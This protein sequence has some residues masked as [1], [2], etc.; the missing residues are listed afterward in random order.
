MA[1]KRYL[2]LWFP[3]LRLESV[4]RKRDLDPAVPFVVTDTVHGA[5]L[6]V[7]ANPA[8]QVRGLRPGL[9]LAD[10]RALCP[11]VMSS[12][13]APHQV[14]RLLDSLRHWAGRLSPWVS[15][16]SDQSLVAD[17]TGCTHL[18]GG[19]AALADQLVED[20]VRLQITLRFGLADT[21]G[22]A[23]AVARYGGTQATPHRSGDAID[24]EARA[25]RSRAHKRSNWERG[26]PAPT[27]VLPADPLSGP[28]EPAPRILAP[29]ETLS[30]LASLP[31]AC[32]RLTAQD[33]APLQRLG[34]KTVGDLT[35]LPRTSLTRRFGVQVM[36]RLDQASGAEPEPVSPAPPTARFA[37][38][39]T[40]PEP[41]GL[42]KDLEAGLARLLPPLCTRLRA[43]GRGGRRFVF[44]AHRTDRSHQSIV[45]TLARAS[46]DAARIAPLIALQLDQI[47]AGFGI[48]MLRLEA[49]VSEPVTATQHSGHALAVDRA[50]THKASGQD[51]ALETLIN[52]L[53]ARLKAE[54]VTRRAPADSHIPEKSA[55]VHTA[56][57]S[58]PS[59]PWPRPP[60]PRPIQLF[61]PE[62][63]TPRDNARPPLAFTWR[64]RIH[65][66]QC[67]KG[68]ERIAPEW[69]LD[70]PDWRS[71]ARDYWAVETAQGARLWIYEAHGAD[72]SGGWFAH[73]CFA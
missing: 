59:P 46:T 7:D 37:T 45:A 10:A 9:P 6:V 15:A 44:S 2:S 21:L 55:Q 16:D 3:R 73:G 11:D 17:L 23:W 39:L 49:V 24:Q 14:A 22:A 36:R 1:H 19:E 48:D 12:A 64:R 5:I 34:L 53:G 31:I 4:T 58:A 52:R 33:M 47:E 38:R 69:W 40:L 43:E 62:P 25:T 54:A 50:E 8:A 57:F 28:C 68:P 51:T 27:P 35:A 63:I 13:C 29:G 65:Q 67:A 66:R 41:V 26:G 32:L 30:A 70:T 71:G 18:A 56:A 20:A 61:P 42:R 72:L 60:A